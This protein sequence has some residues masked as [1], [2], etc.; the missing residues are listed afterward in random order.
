MINGLGSISCEIFSRRARRHDW[1]TPQSTPFQI[2]QWLVI[3]PIVGW[4]TSR[5]FY[6]PYS[7]S[8]F[9]SF[10]LS[11]F[12]PPFL[13]QKR[14][15]ERNENRNK[16]N[17]LVNKNWTQKIK[18]LDKHKGYLFHDPL[19][20]EAPAMWKLDR[21]GRCVI[22][23]SLPC[24]TRLSHRLLIVKWLSRHKALFKPKKNESLW[25]ASV[26]N[27]QENMRG[28]LRWKNVYMHRFHL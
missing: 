23:D 2:S 13:S 25:I 15:R 6:L 7:L 10:F 8:S 16:E 21:R 19:D 18:K 4:I 14:K 9:Y 12:P 26:S 22:H 20:N 27:N 28:V 17:A 24:R 5:S 3:P 1:T 11:F